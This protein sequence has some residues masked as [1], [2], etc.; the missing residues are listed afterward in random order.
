MSGPALDCIQQIAKVRS[1]T[2]TQV[3][4][5]TTKHNRPKYTC[6]AASVAITELIKSPCKF[7]EK[8]FKNGRK[9]TVVD[10]HHPD[11]I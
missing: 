2:K 9:R 3:C 4:C 8:S 7:N 10:K 5:G 6:V 1:N 11:E